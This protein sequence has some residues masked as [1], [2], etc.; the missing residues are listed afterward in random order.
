M[1]V[2]QL[3]S[4]PSTNTYLKELIEEN[5]NLPNYTLVSAVEQTQGRGQ[6]GNVWESRAG[7]NLTI[8]L[9]VRP[10]L[11]LAPKALPFD[12][13]IIAALATRD[14]IAEYLPLK[15]VQIKWPND[16]L[17][18]EKKVAGILIENG[19]N[20]EELEYCI[21]GIGVNVNQ[22]SF[23]GTF[24]IPATSLFLEGEWKFDLHKIQNDIATSIQSL[25]DHLPASLEE[26]RTIYQEHLYRKGDPTKWYQ[27][28]GGEPFQGTLLFV[29]PN[30]KLLLRNEMDGTTSAY[31]FK[32]IQFLHH[33][34]LTL[35]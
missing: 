25:I 10:N 16:L 33:P 32:E 3:D 21:I 29:E 20:G 8:S 13:S 35:D 24:P 22:D 23:E 17:I 7:E 4:I 26:Y 9:Y 30:G 1:N 27:L 34:N 28:P 14:V 11:H 12:I 31:A 18:D 2:I 5:P 15:E 6:K 19:F